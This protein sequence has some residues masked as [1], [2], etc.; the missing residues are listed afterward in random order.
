MTLDETIIGWLNG[1]PVF[2]IAGGDDGD[3]AGGSDDGGGDDSGNDGGGDDKDDSDKEKDYKSLYEAE[4]SHKRNWEKKAKANNDAAKK[5]QDIE[6]ANKTE[7]Q[8]LQDKAA[9][10]DKRAAEAETRALRLEVASEK[11]L[12]AKQAARLVGATKEE[13]EADADELLADF[14]SDTDD[15]GDGT[16]KSGRPKETLRSGATSSTE[17]EITDYK[18]H[19]AKL[20]RY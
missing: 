3:D 11:G 8:K 7:T 15:K 13:L 10:A 16:S 20:P 1:R 2:S 9:E 19:A 5:L 14:K 17:P 4:K 18:A 12:T 6:D